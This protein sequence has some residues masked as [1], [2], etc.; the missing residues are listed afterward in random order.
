[1]GCLFFSRPH[2]SMGKV[3]ER[4]CFGLESGWNWATLYYNMWHRTCFGDHLICFAFPWLSAFNIISRFQQNSSDGIIV[5]FM[6]KQMAAK[7]TWPNTKQKLSWT[8]PFLNASKYANLQFPNI[9][10]DTSHSNT[11]RKRTEAKQR[12]RAEKTIRNY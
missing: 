9:L 10:Q 4:D 2:N 7:Y 3:I 8:R 12:W 6:V 5:E 11:Q 1:M